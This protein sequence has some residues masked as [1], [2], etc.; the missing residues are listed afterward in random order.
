MISCMS[1]RNHEGRY[2]HL[3]GLQFAPMSL[4]DDPFKTPISFG[5]DSVGPS[6]EFNHIHLPSVN[7]VSL[8]TGNQLVLNSPDA[9]VLFVP[10]TAELTYHQAFFPTH[11]SHSVVLPRQV[12]KAHAIAPGTVIVGL[13]K[14]S[15]TTVFGARDFFNVVCFF[16]QNGLTLTEVNRIGLLVIQHMR[17]VL[18][19]LVPKLRSGSGNIT[20]KGPLTFTPTDKIFRIMG[21]PEP[22]PVKK[23]RTDA[24]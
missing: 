22:P 24:K 19:E 16:H 11:D 13:N 12:G 10:K 1:V 6:P 5:P 7:P 9:F 17:C 8:L 2:N 20:F 23:Q 3:R 21:A 15:Q 14:I 4:Y 18:P